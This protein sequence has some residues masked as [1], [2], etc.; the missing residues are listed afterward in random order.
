MEKSSRPNPSCY[1]PK[2]HHSETEIIIP[3]TKRVQCCQ[4][5][6]VR[7]KKWMPST[8]NLRSGGVRWNG[9]RDRSIRKSSGNKLCS[10]F[11]TRSS[12]FPRRRDDW[13]CRIRPLR[14]GVSSPAWPARE[15]G[16]KPT[17]RDGAGGGGLSAEARARRGPHGA[18]HL[19]KSH[20]VLCEGREF[21]R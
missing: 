4:T 21:C 16:G 3:N 1:S 15:A 8:Y 7:S 20:R 9:F 17:A 12:Q 2:I 18:R 6:E 13:R 11:R 5:S 19:K 14:M 10:W